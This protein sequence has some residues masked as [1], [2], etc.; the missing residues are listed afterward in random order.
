MQLLSINAY[1]LSLVSN[2]GVNFDHTLSFDCW[3]LGIFW[4]LLRPVVYQ[5]GAQ[6]IANCCALWWALLNKKSW[7]RIQNL[8]MEMRDTLVPRDFWDTVLFIFVRFALESE[9]NSASCVFIHDF[10]HGLW[11]L[12]QQTA[13]DH[14]HHFFP[15]SHWKLV[16][17]LLAAICWA[18]AFIGLCIC[19]L[20]PLV[21]QEATNQR[22]RSNLWVFVFLIAPLQEEPF[23][24]SW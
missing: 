14:H 21:S 20:L 11:V 22:R 19:I 8:G 3:S 12:Q 10:D 16:F 24:D 13:M 9:S 6:S 1:L 5:P 2:I 23:L 17:A 15:L 7:S 4:L 18:K